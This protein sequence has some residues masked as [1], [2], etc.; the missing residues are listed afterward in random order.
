MTRAKIG[1]ITPIHAVDDIDVAWLVE[2]VHSVQQQEF[3]NW[4]MVVVND[5]SEVDFGDYRELVK[6][7]QTE[8]RL[9]GTRA[10]EAGVSNARNLAA[11]MLDAELLLPL[12]H[13]DMFPETA[14]E[15]YLEAWRGG[16]SAE[17]IVYGDTLLMQENSQRIFEG[18]KYSFNLL[19]DHLFLPIGSMHRKADWQ[20]VGG[21]KPEM[22]GGL[23]DWE[24]W[25]T[26]GEHGVCGYYV[27]KT[28]YTYRRHAR[29]RLAT[30]RTNPEIYARAE[31]QMRQLHLDTFQGRLPMG[32]CSGGGGAAAPTNRPAPANNV[33][34]QMAAVVTG[35]LVN[36]IYIGSSTGNF[37]VQ[38]PRSGIRYLVNGINRPLVM[39]DGRRGVDS[40]DAPLI[41]RM[42]RG[43][44]FEIR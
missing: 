2:A 19:L 36:V 40:Q 29:G 22:N 20:K 30:L 8:K 26:L 17:G 28:L 13:D 38:G 6:L 21:W 41:I 1:V 24:Y 43:K 25:I 10:E 18:H 15:D 7:F 31:A 16:G 27:P 23:E 14:F 44:A 9:K 35:D 39:P 4:S 33:P 3:Q 12:D 11:G 34:V 32:C 37:Y 5:H 42:D